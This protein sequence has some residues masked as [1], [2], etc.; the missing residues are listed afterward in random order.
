MNDKTNDPQEKIE[1]AIDSEE[2]RDEELQNVAGGA[3][4]MKLGDIVGESA[5]DNH[6]KW[7]GVVSMDWGVGGLAW[8]TSKIIA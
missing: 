8:N 7:I 4:Y 2:L 3:G 1:S 6:N 5:D